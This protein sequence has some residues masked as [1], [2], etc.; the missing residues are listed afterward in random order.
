MSNIE[1]KMDFCPLRHS[2]LRSGEYSCFYSGEK[3]NYIDK[4]KCSFYL[5]FGRNYSLR[6]QQN[7]KENIGKL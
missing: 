6:V 2:T 1:K 7:Q 3:C 5:E 4:N